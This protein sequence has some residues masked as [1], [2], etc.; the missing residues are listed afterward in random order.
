MPT[1]AE[2]YCAR[3]G[4]PSR[5]FRRRVFWRTLHPHAVPVAPLL[6]IGN[7]FE[8]DRSLIDACARA[9][10]MEQIHEEIQIHPSNPHHGR[11]LH[12]HARLRISTRRLLRLAACY[13]MKAEPRLR[14][15]GT[16]LTPVL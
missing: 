7:Y 2:L 8:S 12:Q 11:W 9:T 10:C 13:L 16:S 4:C 15:C 5:S 6:L 14:G 1:F 3:N